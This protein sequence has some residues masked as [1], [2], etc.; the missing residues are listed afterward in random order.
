[1]GLF[2]AELKR[3]AKAKP[4]R[5]PSAR[6]GVHIPITLMNLAGCS[7][8][9]RD[10]S[11]KRLTTPKMLPE[12]PKSAQLYLLAQEPTESED[13]FGKGWTCDAAKA[14]LSKLPRD[15]AKGARTGYVVQCAV[16]GGSDGRPG[17]QEVECCR[18]RV[19]SDIE[20]AAPELIVGVGDAPLRWATGL[21]NA[22]AD[23]R[24]AL[25]PVRIGKHACW[26]MPV[27]YPAWASR[28]PGRRKSEHELALEHDLAAAA[29]RM[30]SDGMPPPEV[31]RPPYDAGIEY[32]TGREPGDLQRLEEGLLWCRS[33][34]AVGLDI[35][36]NGFHPHQLD[37]PHVWTAAM[38][39]F[40]RTLAF[41]LDHPDGWGTET[42]RRKVWE[43]FGQ[44]VLLTGRKRCHHVGFE[45]EWMAYFL[46]NQ[47]LR[48]TEWDDT[49]AMSHT[50][51]ER[52]GTHSLDV[53]C[54]LEFGFFLK[55]QSRV[56]VTTPDWIERFS[57]SDVLRYNGMDTKWAYRLADVYLDR[58]ADDQRATNVYERKVRTAPTLVLMSDRGLPMDFACAES[59][60]HS[61]NDRCGA[62]EKRI[63]G[64]PEVRQYARRFG[65]FSPTNPDH[66]LQLM[67]DV[68]DR[69]EVQRTDREGNEKW[70]SNE[71]VLGLM[72]ASEV[73]SASLILE[74][75][76]L[77]RCK[78]TYVLPVVQR[79][80]IGPDGR[81]HGT[82]S[83]MTAISG[84][85]SSELHNWPKRQHREVRQIV[86]AE[87]GGWFVAADQGQIEFRVAGMLSEDR[88]V[89][90]YSW[91][92]YDVHKYWAE[93]MV[94]EYGPI[95]D[96]V[97]SEFKVDWD[98]KGI[99]TLR[100]EAKNGWVFPQIFGSTTDSCAA[101]LHLPEDVAAALGAEFWDEF[102]GV[103]AWQERLIRAYEKN[104]YVETAGGIR[105]RGPHTRNE[106]INHPIQGTA[107]EL[108]IESMNAI[109]E[110]ALEDDDIELQPVFNGHDD[111]SF[112]I[113]DETLEQKIAIITHEMC[114]PRF[115]YVIVP[116]IVEVSVGPN[117]YELEEIGK[118]SSADLF[119]LRNP[120]A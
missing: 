60:L 75:R 118:Y 34:P 50:F 45:Q 25:V 102:A 100:Q 1:M 55:D 23:L 106:L 70:T 111:L 24:G 65:T 17:V 78:T 74:H 51:D 26:Y 9:P 2:Y 116:L 54:R 19:E 11:A 86:T 15:L 7:A 47:I 88:N 61:L 110:R 96:W 12:G 22:A 8:C 32:I 93:R 103:K 16:P 104:L 82:Y 85:L 99:K 107:A 114:K 120:F 84:R 83:S 115:D 81:L 52:R 39:T 18:G 89:V 10:A 72:P 21:T 43:L 31:L 38:G 108:V 14:V 79:K 64:T 76:A 69:P 59:Q 94:Q 73:P 48:M 3:E 46:G 62:L 33:Q 77:T 13:A 6:P 87:P 36:T 101:R 5:P 80:S 42:R 28:K 119:N 4:S 20:R 30:L 113:S 41:S 27:A 98:E 56:D 67:R 35:E 37:D 117:W 109:S 71:E 63:A 58:I 49:M 92:G 91:T 40:E 68:C 53:Q 90:K 29:A 44:A 112:L 95:K 105:R 57:I 97:V 66:V